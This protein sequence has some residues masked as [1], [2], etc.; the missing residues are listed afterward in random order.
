M[1]ELNNNA[2]TPQTAQETPNNAPDKKLTDKQAEKPT[3]DTETTFAD[4][5]VE[6]FRWYNPN[7]KNKKERVQ[8]SRKEYWAMV[9]GAF[10]AMTPMFLCIIIAF[11]AMYLLAY[12]WLKP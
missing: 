4:M 9:R 6:G 12:C 8:L 11:A 10:A 7:K 2:E 3:L 1:E 5:N